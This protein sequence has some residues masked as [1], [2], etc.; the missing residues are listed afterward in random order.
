MALTTKQASELTGLSGSWLREL[1]KRG[2]VKAHKEGREWRFDEPV[3]RAYL[4]GDWISIAEANRRTGRTRDEL[5]G[6]AR[7][8]RVRA[9]RVSGFWLLN[10]ESLLDYLH[11]N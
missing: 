4:N 7:G 8:R 3:L 1:A 5:E 11:R 6:L 9:A 2:W 10:W